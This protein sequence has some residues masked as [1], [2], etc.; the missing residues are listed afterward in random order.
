[1]NLVGELFNPY[2]KEFKKK[3]KVV[4]MTWTI[5]GDEKIPHGIDLLFPFFGPATRT[6][7]NNKWPRQQSGQGEISSFEIRVT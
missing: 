5:E 6:Q 1:M 3:N 7:S 4:R 2:L